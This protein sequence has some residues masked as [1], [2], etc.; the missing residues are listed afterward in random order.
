SW[1]VCFSHSRE[2]CG[3]SSHASS[4]IASGSVVVACIQVQPTFGNGAAN[5]AHSLDLIDQAASRGASLVVLPE[6]ANTG[7]MFASR[8]KAFGLAE[9][10]PGGPS[11]AA[12]AERA[13]RHGMHIVAGIT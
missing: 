9:L 13:A 6:L 2:L 5:G 7:Y 12:W 11:V 3:R 8:E 1:G 10:V 4:G